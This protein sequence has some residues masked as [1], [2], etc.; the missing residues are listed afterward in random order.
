MRCWYGSIDGPLT[1]GAPRTRARH[2]TPRFAREP[3]QSMSVWIRP[4]GRTS[5]GPTKFGGFGL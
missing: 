2:W 4:A 1:E 3:V 5:R